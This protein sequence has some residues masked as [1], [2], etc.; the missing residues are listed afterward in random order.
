MGRCLL[1]LFSFLSHYYVTSNLNVEKMI[2]Q[3]SKGDL[4]KDDVIQYYTKSFDPL[5]EHHKIFI[6]CLDHLIKQEQLEK[7]VFSRIFDSLKNFF[8]KNYQEYEIQD[9][10]IRVKCET[11]VN[12][13]ISEEFIKNKQ[14]D[15]LELK[16]LLMK[17]TKI[18]VELKSERKEYGKIEYQI[19][20]GLLPI[21]ELPDKTKEALNEIRLASVNKCEK[22][23]E[24]LNKM[25]EIVQNE[26][27]ELQNTLNE[28]ISSFTKIN[29]ENCKCQESKNTLEKD[30]AVCKRDKTANEVNKIQENAKME[31]I[32][33]IKNRDINKGEEFDKILNGKTKVEI[34]LVKCHE[35]I[36]SLKAENKKIQDNLEVLKK[37]VTTNSEFCK[38]EKLNHKK[39]LDKIQ[40]QH[41]KELE[42]ARQ[43]AKVELNKYKIENK[44]KKLIE[45]NGEKSLRTHLDP[46]LKSSMSLETQLTTC[47]NDLKNKEVTCEKDKKAIFE[48]CGKTN[49]NLFP[50]SQLYNNNNKM[51]IENNGEREFSSFVK[52]Q[53]EKLNF[54][55]ELVKCKQNLEILKGQDHIGK[56][57]DKSNTS[58]DRLVLEKEENLKKIAQEI[59]NKLQECKANL[60][61][62]T[63]DYNK[64]QKEI[65][66]LKIEIK[67]KETDCLKNKK[68]EFI[69]LNQVKEE[70]NSKNIFLNPCKEIKEEY[71]KKE[72]SLLKCKEDSQNTID[73]LSKGLEIYQ[74]QQRDLEG[75]N[76]KLNLDIQNINEKLKTCNENSNIYS[77]SLRE[78]TGT[79]Q[80]ILENANNNC[81]QII[82]DMEKNCKLSLQEKNNDLIKFKSKI[83]DEKLLCDSNIKNQ[84][85]EFQ[86]SLEKSSKDLTDCK[87]KIEKLEQENKQIT[88]NYNE[89][90]I[91]LCHYTEE[92][93]HLKITIEFQENEIKSLR[94]NLSIPCPPCDIKIKSNLG[95]CKKEKDLITDHYNKLLEEQRSTIEK[96]KEERI[97]ITESSNEL[98]KQ[99]KDYKYSIKL[100]DKKAAENLKNIDECKQKIELKDNQMLKLN[101]ETNILINEKETLKTKCS[102]C[103]IDYYINEIEKIKKD[104]IEMKNLLKTQELKCKDEFNKFNKS[105][106]EEIKHLQGLKAKLGLFD[107]FFEGLTSKLK[108]QIS[109]SAMSK[110]VADKHIKQSL[111][112]LNNLSEQAKQQIDSI[113]INDR[114]VLITKLSN[115]NKL[116][117]TELKKTIAELSNVED[118]IRILNKNYIM[119]ENIMSMTKT[120]IDIF[121]NQIE[122]RDFFISNINEE[123]NELKNFQSEYKTLITLVNTIIE[124][125]NCAIETNTKIIELLFKDSRSSSVNGNNVCNIHSDLEKHMSQ[126]NDLLSNF[127]T[128]YEQYIKSSIEESTK[129]MKINF[130]KDIELIKSFENKIKPQLEIIESDNSKYLTK[131]DIKLSPTNTSEIGNTDKKSFMKKTNKII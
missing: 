26:K 20:P 83:N 67:T 22:K 65:N 107:I 106:T 25:L 116:N 48:E 15:I 37:E 24:T 108:L 35:E 88:K 19:N 95:D 59:Q 45:N 99:N 81:N 42:H 34:K 40:E 121:K 96:L 86:K 18:N 29:D 4:S 10:G 11:Y 64:C 69:D 109:S 60:N 61:T 50:A 122:N 100:L 47:K 105:M 5:L 75:N 120:K 71:E 23:L 51:K 63:F 119:N 56:L 113:L 14:A 6:P 8:S 77:K 54:E 53:A 76:G 97:K 101:T 131:I 70:S 41:S 94:K 27:K 43:E 125:R 130:E 52:L 87:E 62:N 39:A 126:I 129:N 73:R 12:K 55:A 128:E 102:V 2:T 38:N 89:I 93:K 72:K 16:K 46:K 98:T 110:D 82:S 3:I 57:R 79:N 90:Q 111:F 32:K 21:D 127:K 66:L 117:I 44:N 9:L 17:D 31:K 58:S 80:S 78:C 91:S 85:N 104:N 49:N 103:Q 115:K 118:R 7:S 124:D 28:K 33:L 68:N 84:N 36:D 13:L 74:Q 123:L 112:Y 114:D 1:I 92:E 30:L